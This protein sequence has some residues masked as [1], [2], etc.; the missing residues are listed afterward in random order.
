MSCHSITVSLSHSLFL[1]R[2]RGSKQEEDHQLKAAKRLGKA[3]YQHIKNDPTR[4]YITRDDFD[5]FFAGL[6][7]AHA[8]ADAAFFFFDKVRACVLPYLCLNCSCSTRMLHTSA[9][10]SNGGMIGGSRTPSRPIRAQRTV[11]IAL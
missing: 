7:N 5:P 11:Y 10:S 3:L 1:D 8:E 4:N 9:S 6:H 2:Y